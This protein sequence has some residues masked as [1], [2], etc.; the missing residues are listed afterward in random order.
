[1][2]KD[3][4]AKSLAEA[5]EMVITPR[6]KQGIFYTYCLPNGVELRDTTPEQEAI[7]DFAIEGALRSWNRSKG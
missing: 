4:T 5:M 7:V 1:M 3:V 2:C 6:N